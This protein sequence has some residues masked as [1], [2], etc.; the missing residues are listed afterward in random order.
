MKNKIIWALDATQSPKES[1]NL[2]K[3]MRIWATALNCEIQPVALFSQSA[4]N[5]PVELAFPWKE[6]YE[7]IAKASVRH[8]LK[9]SGIKK[10]LPPEILFVPAAS[11]QQLAYKM[12]QYAE[13]TKAIMICANT[14]AKR[15]WNPFRLGG[16][17]ETL[18]AVS[19][20]PVLLLNPKT[21]VKKNKI[22]SIFFPT[23]FQKETQNALMR[24]APW[25][26]ALNAK[27]TLYN[28]VENPTIY[29]AELNGYWTP[30]D[31]RGLLQDIELARGKKAKSCLS[32]LEQN[33]IKA[34]ALLQRQ[35]RPL[36]HDIILRAKKD[37]ADLIAITGHTGAITQAL[38]GSVPRDILLQANCPVL[39]FHKPKTIRKKIE[40]SAVHSK[41]LSKEKSQEVYQ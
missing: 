40:K 22:S 28:Q 8:F 7:Q 12:A 32:L 35:E 34:I 37:K 38:I 3:A 31:M 5:F 18:A 30:E 6:K 24:L 27:I 21:Q 23:D 4:L 19:H 2:I 20:T 11:S 26:K 10:T 36:S 29:A 14:R 16:F 25:A 17:A 33:Q 15:T 9:D 13:K 41:N 39:I 1:K